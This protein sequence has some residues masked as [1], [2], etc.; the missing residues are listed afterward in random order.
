MEK[1]YLIKALAEFYKKYSTLVWYAR[2]PRMGNG[3]LPSMLEVQTFPEFK[4]T[5]PDV[6]KGML[7]AMMKAQ[8]DYP[9]DCAELDNEKSDNWQHGFNSGMLACI[10]FVF[11][12]D[13][14]GLEDARAEFPMLDT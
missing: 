9:E 2:K 10:S 4:D 13:E 11:T 1:A 6:I 5:P 3:D 8:A 12:A 7:I 14:C